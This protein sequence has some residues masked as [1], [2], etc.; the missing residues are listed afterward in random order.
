MTKVTIHHVSDILCV[1]AYIADVRVRELTATFGDQLDLDFRTLTVF[2]DVAS[3]LAS[4]WGERGGVAGYARHVRETVEK[5]EHVTL[6]ADVWVRNTPSS[7]LPPHLYLCAARL[8]EQSGE[9]APGSREALAQVLRRRFFLAA[10][11]IS[12]T[13]VLHQAVAEAGLAHAPVDRLLFDGR[14]HAQLAADMQFVREQDVRSS[15]TMLFN[16]GRQ[17]LTGNV[18]YRIIEAN[19]R[20]LLERPAAQHSWC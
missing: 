18:G 14:A 16:E 9:I 5:F 6:H 17:R 1:W 4:G 7:C 3:K 8:A 15:P 19:V 2:G 12:S 20:E 11:D 10:E 13:A